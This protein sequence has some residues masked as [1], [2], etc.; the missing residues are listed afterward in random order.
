[1]KASALRAALLGTTLL[2]VGCDHASKRAAKTALEGAPARPVVGQVLDLRYR[3]NRDVAFELLRWVPERPR[4]TLLAVAGALAVVA[5]GLALLRRTAL[6]RGAAAVA[7]LLAGAA[8][9][10]RRPPPRRC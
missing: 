4:A 7:L 1:M 10:H 9:N 3:E 6:D 2:L 5:L 8:G